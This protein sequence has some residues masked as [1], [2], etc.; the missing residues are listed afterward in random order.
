MNIG[1]VEFSHNSELFS[2]SKAFV[3]RRLYGIYSITIA[4]RHQRLPASNGFIE[5][6]RGTVGRLKWT[7]RNA[8]VVIFQMT[9]INEQYQRNFCV[10]WSLCHVITLTWCPTNRMVALSRDECHMI[11]DFA[12]WLEVCF[13]FAFPHAL[14]KHASL[15]K[16][17]REFRSYVS[18]VLVADQNI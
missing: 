7:I 10:M 15:C 2:G 11:Y 12:W 18:D 17:D 9:I 5:I 4:G 16:F 13:G 3:L 6:R 8:T 1:S 14:H